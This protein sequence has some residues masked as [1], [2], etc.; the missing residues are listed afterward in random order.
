MKPGMVLAPAALFPPLGLFCHK[1]HVNF[2]VVL[3]ISVKNGTGILIK[4][5]LGL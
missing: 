4:I 5:T 2:M 1:I 3:F